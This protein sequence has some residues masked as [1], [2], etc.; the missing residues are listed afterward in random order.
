MLIN[1]TKI[2]T[3]IAERKMTQSE[4]ALRCG[5]SRQSINT[6][7]RRGTCELRTAGKLADGL[8]IDVEEIIREVV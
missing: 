3:L 7:I 6:I 1:R 4:L 2:L 8:G 5:I